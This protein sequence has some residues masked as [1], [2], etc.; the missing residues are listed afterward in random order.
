MT[1]IN[2]SKKICYPHFP[3]YL[4]AVWHFVTGPINTS[5][6]YKLDYMNAYSTEGFLI[7]I[8]CNVNTCL[9]L[10]QRYF[11]KIMYKIFQRK[12]IY[13]YCKLTY[14]MKKFC[15]S[16]AFC[17]ILLFI[18]ELIYNIFD[19]VIQSNKVKATCL[20]CRIIVA[21]GYTQ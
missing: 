13:L 5:V 8:M 4:W 11:L 7:P 14:I 16:E 10:T 21:L 2:F 12:S 6:C 17:W 9:Y 1:R 15:V 20:F 19:N 18:S 3:V